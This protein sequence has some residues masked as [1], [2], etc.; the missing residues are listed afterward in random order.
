MPQI[1]W[2]LILRMS[3]FCYFCVVI[4]MTSLTT[5]CL[6]RIAAAAVLGGLI[7]LEREYR[8]KD[9]GMRTHFLVALGSALFMIVSQYGFRDVLAAYEKVNLDPSRIASQVVTGIGFVGAGLIIFQRSVI[10][11]LTTAAGL[12]VTAAIGLTCGAGLYALAA[13]TTALVLLCLEALHTLL[14]RFGTRYMTVTLASASKKSIL[15]MT[16]RI[17]KESIEVFAFNITEQGTGGDKTYIAKVEMKVK[18]KMYDE[19]MD[20]LLKEHNDV[21]LVSIE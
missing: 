5:E 14:R 21:E 2:R 19:W 18:R 3:V 17:N 9:A 6:L 1:F 20:G 12:W 16:G 15:S 13:A 11:G 7:G 8:A 4:M 10:R